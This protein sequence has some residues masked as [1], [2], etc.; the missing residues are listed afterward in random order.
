MTAVQVREVESAIAARF[1]EVLDLSNAG[2]ATPDQVLRSRGLAALAL[3]LVT[4]EEPQ[5]CAEAVID[6]FGDNGIDAVYA[7]ESTPRIVLVQTKFRGERKR[8]GGIDLGDMHIFLSGVRDLMNEQ[9]DRFGG[10]LDAIAPRLSTL[11]HQSGTVIE[12]VVGYTTDDDLSRPVRQALDDELRDANDGERELLRLRVIRLAELHRFSLDTA[13]GSAVELEA[14]LE[15]WGRLEKPYEAYYGTVSAHQ[16][17]YWYGRFGGRL[18]ERNIRKALGM[19][20]VNQ[21]LVETLSEASGHFWYLNNGITVLCQKVLR[22]PAGA[23]QRSR[24][25]FILQG[26]SVVN[27]AQTVMSIGEA[28]RVTGRDPDPARVWIRIISLDACPADFAS[29]IT[30]ATNTQNRVIDSDFVALDPTQ[31]RLCRDFALMLRKS[32]VVKRGEEAAAPDDGC[33]LQEATIALACAQPDL[34]YAVLAHH[35][36]GK[37]WETG[38]DTDYRALFRPDVS[39]AEV[40]RW[41]QVNRQVE[42]AVLLVST[43]ATA[44]ERARAAHA[45]RLVVHLTMGELDRTRI[46]DPLTDWDGHLEQAAEL[47]PRV[48]ALLHRHAESTFPDLPAVAV[49]RSIG[50]NRQLAALIKADLNTAQT[51][52]ALVRPAPA[53]GSLSIGEVVFHL[54]GRGSSA[55]GR[56]QGNGLVVRAGSIAAREATPFLQY[57]A[58]AITRREW[59]IEQGVLRPD[60]DRNALVL[61]RDEFFDSASQAAAVM[62]GRQSNGRTEWRTAE[63]LSINQVAENRPR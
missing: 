23:A 57:N 11:L 51:E 12:L 55:R 35:Q 30:R 52:P 17:A 43:G 24:G 54:S 61:V 48:L 18:F 5:E 7:D 20:K 33:T 36:L 6:G 47:A 41:V 34:R 40:W 13:T 4:G 63:G 59:L 60:F 25:H 1:S 45:I 15:Q 62:L 56:L 14:T 21:R 46:A 49:F 58:S 32:Y 29:Q 3:Q 8:Q 42:Q 26:V 2:A 50:R 31:E 44:T 53:K 22:A 38:D 19:T 27:G 37:L 39:A 16:V 9:F 10:K 28:A